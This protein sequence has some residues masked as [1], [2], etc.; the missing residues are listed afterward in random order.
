MLFLSLFSS[1]CFIILVIKFN[2]LITRS[3]AAAARLG[4]L[5]AHEVAQ[6]AAPRDP[7]TSPIQM[8]NQVCGTGFYLFESNR[9]ANKAVYL[10]LNLLNLNN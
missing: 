2:Y 3:S 5:S 9:A 10:V 7:P 6:P 1:V 8:M 4:E